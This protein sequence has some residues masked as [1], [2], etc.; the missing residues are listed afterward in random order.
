M[1]EDDDTE[2]L[3]FESSSAL[4]EYGTYMF[5]GDVHPKNSHP[6]V[7][8]II[9]QNSKD[10]RPHHLSL[11][12]N[13]GGG[14]MSECTAIIDMMKA[15][16]IPVYTYGIGQVSSAACDILAAGEKGHRYIFPNTI[17]M[18]HSWS[19]Q[20]NIGGKNNAKSLKKNEETIN[21]IVMKLLKENLGLTDEEFIYNNVLTDYDNYL[22]AEEAIS[23]GIADHIV[24]KF[25]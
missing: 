20:V 9:R 22:T 5:W 14:W 12:I 2:E 11:F 10:R 17:L 6:L 25:F 18:V 24:T 7:E 19:G 3:I 15:S 4:E 16:K 21:K 13:S 23:L 8:F 1:T